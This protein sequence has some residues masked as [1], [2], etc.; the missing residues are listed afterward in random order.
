MFSECEE[1]TIHIDPTKYKFYTSVSAPSH[2]QCAHDCFR[3]VANCTAVTFSYE[4]YTSVQNYD[5]R[6]IVEQICGMWLLSTNACLLVIRG[7]F[8]IM[9]AAAA[10]SNALLTHFLW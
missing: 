2:G 3:T 10:V 5:S 4:T 6:T 8:L 9:F 7:I 1:R